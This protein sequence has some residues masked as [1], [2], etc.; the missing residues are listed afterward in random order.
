VVG[1]EGKPHPRLA[2]ASEE[3][4]EVVLVGGGGIGVAGAGGAVAVWARFGR[5]RLS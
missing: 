5:R 2:F 3:G 1:G 4:G